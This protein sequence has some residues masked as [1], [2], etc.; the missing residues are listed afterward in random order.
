MTRI[1]GSIVTIGAGCLLFGVCVLGYSSAALVVDRVNQARGMPTDRD[2][3]AEYTL[4]RIALLSN[5]SYANH[6]FLKSLVLAS[7]G[8]VMAVAGLGV[9]RRSSTGRYLAI[10]ACSVYIIAQLA[11]FGY[12]YLEGIPAMERLVMTPNHSTSLSSLKVRGIVSVSLLIVF[13]ACALFLLTRRRI[14]SHFQ[15]P[16][17]RRLVSLEELLGPGA[18]GAAPEAGQSAASSGT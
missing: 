6:R 1:K 11:A 10:G 18:S 15:F 16:D 8:L 9:L 13:P 7:C 4:A 14:A 5:S 12:L 3:L 17:R 2:D